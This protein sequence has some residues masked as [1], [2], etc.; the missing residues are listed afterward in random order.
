MT[1]TDQRGQLLVQVNGSG[2]PWQLCLRGISQV[3]KVSIGEI[4]SSELGVIIKPEPNTKQI[5]IQL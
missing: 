5:I 4:L 1:V 3:A 2:K